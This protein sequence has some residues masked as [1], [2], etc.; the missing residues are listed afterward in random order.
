MIFLF[1]HLYLPVTAS[2]FSLS[3][4]LGYST[5][6]CFESSFL[7]SAADHLESDGNLPVLH[8]L[9]VEKNYMVFI[10]KLRWI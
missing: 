6:G 7:L 5:R 4:I 8:C 9:Q 2:S 10:L 1:I 3:I